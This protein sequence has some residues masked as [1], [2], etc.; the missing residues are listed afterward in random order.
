MKQIERV[1][2]PSPSPG[3]TRELV[4]HRYGR[5]GARPKAY[6]QASLHADE[7]PAMLVAHHLVRAL[8]AA[9]ARILG[10]I[11]VLPVANPI[12]LDQEVG[13]THLGRHELAGGGNFNRAWPDLTDEAA[14]RLAGEL[15]ADAA[16]NER[17]VR[18]ALAEAAAA[19]AP[20]G[21]LGA[22]RR[23]AVMRAADADIVLDLHCDSEALLYLYLSRAMEDWRA[24]ADL[25]AHTG[26]AWMLL[27]EDPG[28][29]SFEDVMSGTWRKLKARFPT[30]PLPRGCLASTL[31]YRGQS[32]VDDAT[33]KADAD[34]LMRF[35]AGRGLI[36]GAAPAPDTKGEAIALE[37]VDVVRAPH[38]GLVAM[39]ATLGQ[40]VKAGAA[41]AELI[42]LNDPQAPR[43]ILA[44][45]TDGQVFSHL[46][47]RLV[48][49]GA[50]IAKIAGRTPLP[51]RTGYLLED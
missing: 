9:N 51:G 18:A 46:R 30:H 49:A 24:G 37:A 10:E 22:L 25:L 26:A 14:A 4:F 12:G 11:I 43:T 13:G 8:D 15:G 7:V 2:L 47:D 29:Q 44:S 41:V 5:A 6:I 1:T 36:S 19:L 23:A 17:A 20:R 48:R 28:G 33:A 21:A 34:N 45:E 32:D 42:D 16:A 38:A 39:R 27:S 40:R 50:P 3:T 35:L 31:E